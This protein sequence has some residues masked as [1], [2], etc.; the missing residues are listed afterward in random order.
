M[1]EILCRR[2]NRFRIYAVIARVGRVVNTIAI[3]QSG[4]YGGSKG[5]QCHKDGEVHIRES[6]KVKRYK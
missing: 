5:G 6:T 3:V 4:M 2:G 1:L